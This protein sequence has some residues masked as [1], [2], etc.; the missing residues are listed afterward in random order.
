LDSDFCSDGGHTGTVSEYGGLE[1]YSSILKIN[2]IN[3]NKK[4]MLPNR[5]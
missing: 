2:L 4:N 3:P 1:N 5:V